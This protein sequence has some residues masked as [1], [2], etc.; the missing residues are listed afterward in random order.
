MQK[1]LIEKEVFKGIKFKLVDDEGRS[2]DCADKLREEFE[3]ELLNGIM[4][5]II[6]VSEVPHI[7][8]SFIGVIGYM[9]QQID[10][11]GDIVIS[12]ANEDVYNSLTIAGLHKLNKVTIG[13]ND[14]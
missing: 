1:E 6:D 14:G 11:K 8:S 10:D 5:Y 13:V 4:H 9:E 7:N 12:G 3:L 2:R